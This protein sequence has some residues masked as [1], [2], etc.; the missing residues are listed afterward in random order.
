MSPILAKMNFLDTFLEKMDASKII[1]NKNEIKSDI[2]GGS[3]TPDVAPKMSGVC[4]FILRE[5][6][7]YFHHGD[8]AALSPIHR[9]E[10]IASDRFI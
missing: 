8:L 2:L 9:F 1:V 4:W 3:I 7:A 10:K 6:L 5:K